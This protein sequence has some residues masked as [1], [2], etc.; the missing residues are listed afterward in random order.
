MV[1]AGTPGPD[2]RPRAGE[3]QLWEK[4]EL[5]K[6]A[7]RHALDRYPRIF[8]ACS[9]GKDS[10]VLVDLVREVAPDLE[11]VG[12][13]TGYEFPETLDVRRATRR[14][15]RDALSLGVPA[16]GRASVR[17]ESEYDGEIVRHER[18]K[19]CEMKLPALAT[20]FPQYDAWITG[21]RRDENER[22]GQTPLVE[23]GAPEGQPARLLDPAGDLG[24]H[25]DERR[26]SYHPL[27]NAGYASLGCQ[28]CTNRGDG[29][30]RSGRFA[31]T[32][33]AGQECGLHA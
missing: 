5:S 4:V 14:G 25:P 7:I 19:C 12:I 24:L 11:F 8:A 2:L 29:S 32:A 33:N 17:I 21:L 31:G 30:E 9:F 20:A 6:L 10:R 13:D 28:P 23:P 3:M 1:S 18:Y 26:L 15:N 22:R 16:G 27:Y